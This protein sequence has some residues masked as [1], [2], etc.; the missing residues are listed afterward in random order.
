MLTDNL[1]QIVKYTIEKIDKIP[2]SAV[3]KVLETLLQERELLLEFFGIMNRAVVIKEA[4]GKV[5]FHNPCAVKWGVVNK[6]D[7][8]VSDDFRDVFRE[9]ESKFS[10]KMLVFE[11]QRVLKVKDS[12]ISSMK[13]DRVFDIFC[14]ASLSQSRYM[15]IFSDITEK[16]KENFDENQRKVISSI[17]TLLAGIA[18]EIKNPLSSIY[19]HAQIAKKSLSCKGENMDKVEKSV[20]IILSEVGRLNKLV[21]D[22]IQSLRPSKFVEKYEDINDII[23]EVSEMLLNEIRDKGIFFELVL[24]NSLPEFLCDKEVIKIL[25]LNLLRN[26]IESIEGSNGK[27]VIK[28]SVITKDGE[29]Y[30]SISI[31]DNGKGIPEEIKHRIFE[32]YFTTKHYGS[33]LGLSIVYKIVKDYNGFIEFD[34]K[35]GEGTEFKICLPIGDRLKKLTV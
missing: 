30:I 17:D 1:S 33:G 19:L 10:D 18:H 3:V 8:N 32:P 2:D 9:I 21:N 31:K 25:I 11:T 16:T 27:I 6:V 26:S 20:E 23:K 22:F 28:T 34:S 24:D 13:T 29:D 14:V 15:Y 7:L 12:V 35:E 4:N 5:L